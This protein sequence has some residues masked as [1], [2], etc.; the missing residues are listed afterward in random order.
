MG[1]VSAAQWFAPELTAEAKRVR[2]QL[3]PADVV[4]GSFGREEKL[5]SPVF[6]DA[7]IEILR[8]QPDALFLWTGRGQLPAIQERLEAAGVA[9]RCRFIGW[10]NTKLYA[11]V[12]D[13]FLDSFP[14]PCGFT[15][16]EA[17]AA[18][19]PIVLFDSPES[20]TGGINALVAPLFNAGPDSSPE[21]RLAR[22]IFRPQPGT[23]YYS[24]PSEAREYVE[25]AVRL[26]RDAALRE[27]AG[28]AARS[29]V[30]RLMAD[31]ARAARIYIDHV[32]GRGATTAVS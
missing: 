19:K 21:A 23:D 28:N 2:E 30:E 13:V 12:L 11:Q 31:R 32:L 29:F 25:I 18:G 3:G 6:I 24:R 17:M 27:R 8:G 9:A 26:G 16:Y 7:V 10:V 20:T 4:Y 22:E 5:N 14:F 1:P 15:L